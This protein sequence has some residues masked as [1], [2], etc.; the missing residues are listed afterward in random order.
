L[1]PAKVME[2]YGI[3]KIYSGVYQAAIMRNDSKIFAF[4][5]NTVN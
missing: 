5:L 4:G 1:I 3:K 2:N